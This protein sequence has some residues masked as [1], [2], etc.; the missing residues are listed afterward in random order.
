MIK[1][2]TL[3]TENLENRQGYIKEYKHQLFSH[4]KKSLLHLDILDFL[5]NFL[6]YL[7]K[8]HVR[9]FHVNF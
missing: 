3:I 7:S 4:H 2:E 9:S 8:V 6:L 1:L 5:L